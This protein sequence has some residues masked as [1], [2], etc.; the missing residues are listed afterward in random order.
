M[1]LVGDQGWTELRE[2]D[3]ASQG[4]SKG[5][6][7]VEEHAGELT[8]QSPDALHELHSI[9]LIKVSEPPRAESAEES[10]AVAIQKAARKWRTL[11]EREDAR[12]ERDPWFAPLEAEVQELES[13]ENGW[14]DI[15]GGRWSTSR[16]LGEFAADRLAHG[17]GIAVLPEGERWLCTFT[18]G[19]WSVDQRCVHRLSP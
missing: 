11:R 10:A 8:A 17:A 14:C 1:K 4:S 9:E 2:D 19:P 7:N 13:A 3:M 15:I 16:F 12:D 18:N 6:S 5:P